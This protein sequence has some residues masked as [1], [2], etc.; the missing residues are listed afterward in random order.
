MKEL[1]YLVFLKRSIYLITTLPDMVSEEL[2]LVL[3]ILLKNGLVHINGKCVNNVYVVTR[4]RDKT[5][6][7]HHSASLLDKSFNI[8]VTVPD[9]VIV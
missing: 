6:R 7:T 2:F 9:L 5:V 3:F 1:F 4:G 8:G